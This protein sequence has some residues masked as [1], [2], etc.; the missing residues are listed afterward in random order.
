[1]SPKI[2]SSPSPSYSVALRLQIT[3]KPGMLGKVTSAIGK[4]GGDIG[5]VDI[6]SASRSVIVRDITVNARDDH[7]SSEIIN[8]VKSIPGIQVLNYS[9]R[10]FLLHHGGKIEIKS[11]I[12][13][14]TRD[15][16]SMIYTPGVGRVSKV[17]AEDKSKVWQLTIK[18]NSVAIVTDGTA[19]LGLGDLGPEAAL[20]V[21]EGKAALFKEFADIDAFPICLS[22]KVPKEIIETVERISPV[23]GGINL[24]DISSPRCFQIED[25]LKKRLDIPVLHDDQHGTAITI[26]AAL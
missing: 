19:V 8:K 6:V 7:H 26:L 24:E 18:R 16:L 25:E 17:I 13:V 2:P 20:P 3:N 23:F 14:K 11:K 9:D 1:M 15:N 4:A 5:A 21:M 12:P 22:T 10:T